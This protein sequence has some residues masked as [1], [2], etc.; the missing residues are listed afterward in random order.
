M[1]TRLRQPVTSSALVAFLQ[2]GDSE[3][4]CLSFRFQ[5]RRSAFGCSCGFFVLE[6]TKG[7]FTKMGIN[8]LTIL[9]DQIMGWPVIIV[10]I[11][12]GGKIIV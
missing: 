9:I 3:L 7:V 10:V 12:P 4:K 6:D 11:I 8:N 2:N 5:L 1:P